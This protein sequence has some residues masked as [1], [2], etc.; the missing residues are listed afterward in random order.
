MRL[1]PNWKWAY[2]SRDCRKTGSEGGSLDSRRTESGPSVAIL[3]PSGCYLCSRLNE[4]KRDHLC[5]SK[6]ITCVAGSVTCPPGGS[7]DN[8]RNGSEVGSRDTCRTG[9]GAGHVTPAEPEVALTVLSWILAGSIFTW[10]LITL[11]GMTC[12][13]LGRTHVWRGRSLA[14]LGRFT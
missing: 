10:R 6:K 14:P 4:P 12:V 1:P 9:I 7:R 8:R 2:G 5:R 13:G 11:M 3:D